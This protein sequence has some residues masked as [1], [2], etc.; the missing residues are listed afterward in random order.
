M[1][2]AVTLSEEIVALFTRSRKVTD[3]KILENL[4]SPRIQKLYFPVYSD[5]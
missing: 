4:I 2:S 5:D 1:C 3:A